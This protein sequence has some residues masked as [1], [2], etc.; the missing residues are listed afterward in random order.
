[1]CSQSAVNAISGIQILKIFWGGMPDP[2]TNVV[3]SAIAPPPKKI[4]QSFRH[5]LY[6]SIG[7]FR[8]LENI[9]ILYVDSACF[10]LSFIYLLIYKPWRR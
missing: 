1:M 2:P 5:W 3:P 4:S 10:H 9:A 8:K 7:Y 6:Q